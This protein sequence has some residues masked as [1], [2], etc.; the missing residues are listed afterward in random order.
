MTWTAPEIQPERTLVGVDER[1]MLQSW[2][3]FHRQSLLN[4]CGGLDGE[5]LAL[6]SVPPSSLSLLGLVRH[7]T[8]VERGWFRVSAAG[9][10][11]EP[12]YGSPEAPDADFDDLDGL[13][14]AAVFG[15]FHA[16]VAACDAAVAG[17]SLDHI[18][19]VPWRSD[20]YTLRWVYL[21]MIEEYARH[22]GHADLLRER[23]DG[24]TGSF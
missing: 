10:S 23:I 7:L 4:K 22:N 1:P 17:L 18:F 3:D 15:A 8:E 11:L 19:H 6:R 20:G 24:V 13:P 21:H 5:R 14:A 9:E 2:L 16:E 12:V